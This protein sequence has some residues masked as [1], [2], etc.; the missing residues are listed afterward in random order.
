MNSMEHLIKAVIV[1]LLLLPFV[2]IFNLIKFFIN[3]RASAID[4]TDEEAVVSQDWYG[5]CD[6]CGKKD[7]LHRLDGKKYCALCHAKIKTERDFSQ[8]QQ[9]GDNNAR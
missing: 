7:G 5:I 3:R 2:L 1:A 9:N 4:K 8:K 6:H